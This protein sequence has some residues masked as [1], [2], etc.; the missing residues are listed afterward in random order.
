MGLLEFDKLPINTLIGA[1]WKT[2]NQ[3]TANQLIGDEYKSKY[4]LTKGVCRLLSLLKPIEDHYYNKIANRP[5][6]EDPLFILGVVVQ[7]LFTMCSLA[8]NILGTRPLIRPFS[9]I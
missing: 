6:E 1:D 5:L 9:H 3:V 2:F 7:R 4:R 8:I